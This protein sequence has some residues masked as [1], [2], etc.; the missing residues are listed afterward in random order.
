MGC[1]I[2]FFI[3]FSISITTYA[4]TESEN[5]L[6]VNIKPPTGAASALRYFPNLRQRSKS[7]PKNKKEYAKTNLKKN[8]KK[9]PKLAKNTNKKQFKKNR[10]TASS[11]RDNK[12]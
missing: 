1:L 11:S 9:A 5:E 12:F 7:E 2:S 3:A 10:T 6:S 4:Q 8:K